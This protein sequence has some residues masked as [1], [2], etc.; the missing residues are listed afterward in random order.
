VAGHRQ[1]ATLT[2]CGLLCL[3]SA[4]AQTL[5]ISPARVLVDEPADVHVTGL[6]PGEHTTLRAELVDGAGQQWESQSEFVADAQGAVDLAAQVPVKGSYKTTSSMGP[7]WSMTPVAKGVTV[8]RPPQGFA[9][10]RIDFQLMRDGKPIAAAQLEQETFAAGVHEVK[11]TGQLHGALFLPADSGPHPGLLVLGGSEGGLPARRAAWLASHGYAALALAYFRYENLPPQLEAIPLEY[12][13]QALEW[14]QGRP[15]ISSGQIAIMGV[16][17]GAELALQLGSMYPKTKAVVAYAPASVL[18][19]ACCG[20]NRVPFAW[21][22]N[23]A[24]L[25]FASGLNPSGSDALAAAI[26]VENTRGSI[27][28][29]DGGQDHIWD[30]SGMAKAIVDR[31]KHAHFGPEVENF[32]YPHAGH[33][34]GRPE[35]IPEWHGALRHPVSGRPTDYGGTPEGNALSSIDASPKVLDFLRRNL[36]SR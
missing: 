30:S 32:T 2:S 7:I 22:W 15:E 16:S 8:Y 29:V 10:Q 20:Q 19:R 34:A 6:H 23:G 5:A 36:A 13:L 27:L 3:F 24:P 12:F 35:I 31:L 21:T 17:R 25:V 33:I 26:R 14:M 4:T 18:H 28:L 1:L 11:L 9:P